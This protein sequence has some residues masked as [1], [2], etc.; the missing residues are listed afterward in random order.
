MAATQLPDGDLLDDPRTGGAIRYLGETLRRNFGGEWELRPGE[1]MDPDVHGE[2]YSYTGRF[3]VRRRAPD[4]DNLLVNYPEY[5]I[6]DTIEDRDP[7]V[8]L[9]EGLKN[10]ARH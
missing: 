2:Q 4:S 3:N 6:R 1:K 9:D 5:T 8:I 7:A 10:Y